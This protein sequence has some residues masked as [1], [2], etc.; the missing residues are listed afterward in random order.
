MSADVASHFSNDMD[1][2][3]IKSDMTGDLS[4]S[5]APTLMEIFVEISFPTLIWPAVTAI[6]APSFFHLRQVESHHFS[7]LLDSSSGRYVLHL[8]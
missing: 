5:D 7:A 4:S 8:V 3:T 2:L 6:V 1:L